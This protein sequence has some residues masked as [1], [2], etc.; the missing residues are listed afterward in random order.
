MAYTITEAQ[1]AELLKI[2]D[3]LVGKQVKNGLIQESDRKDYIQEL[4]LIMVQ[5]QDDWTVPEGVRLESYANTV[6]EKRLFNIWRKK[7]PKKDVMN[8]AISLNNTFLDADGEEDEFIN[9]VTENGVMNTD[10]EI[11]T[12]W[13]RDRL[14]A[15]VR[16]FVAT[17]PQDDQTLC[18]LLMY[19]SVTETAGILGKSRLFIW[20]KIYRIRDK[21][22]Q[23]GLGSLKKNTKK[24]DLMVIQNG[25]K[26]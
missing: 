19:H 14:I 17:L 23:A 18:E 3:N 2:A 24:S 9:L 26:K 25:T 20:R 5:H 13:S 15:E 10:T 8:D 22:T 4:M 11:S 6:M 7:H 12:S 16:L 21:M 1:A